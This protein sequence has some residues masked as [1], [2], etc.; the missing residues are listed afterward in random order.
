MATGMNATRLG[1]VTVSTPLG[2]LTIVASERGV[3]AT[4]FDDETRT[5]RS[6]W[7]GPS[8]T[9]G[10]SVAPPSRTSGGGRD[11]FEGGRGTFSTPVDLG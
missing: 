7:I 1:V 4:T 3:L 6:T 10:P 8:R 5:R 11:Y 2:S 9:V